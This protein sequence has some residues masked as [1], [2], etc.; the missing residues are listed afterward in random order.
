MNVAELSKSR[1]FNVKISEK[2]FLLLIVSLN[3]LIK[4]IPAAMVELG[5]DEVYYWTYALFP[6][7]S[8]FDHPPMVGFTIQLFTLN[9]SLNSEFFIR[10]GSLVLS[11]ASIIFLF[12]LVKRIY[13]TQAAYISAFLFTAS[14]YFNVISGL[15]ILPDTPQVFFVVVALFFGLPAVLS[16]NP[17]KKDSLDFILFGLFSGLAFL[18]KYHSLFLWAGVGLYILFCNRIWLKKI[19]FYL[20]ILLTV[21]AIIPVIY[22]NSINEFVSFTFHESRVSLFSKPLNLSSFLQFNAGQFFYQNPFLFIL[23]ILTLY[24][25]FRNRRKLDHK[26]ILLLLLSLPLIILFILFSLFQKTLP[27]WSG[28]A[29]IG[30][31]ILSCGWLTERLLIRLRRIIVFIASSV[32]FIFIML[33]FSILQI[34]YGLLWHAQNLADP[35]KTGSNDLTLEMYGWKQARLK[36]HELLKRKGI[37]EKD[38]NKVK[39]ISNK[40]FPAAHIDYY[41]AHPMNIDLL[42]P[43]QLEQSHKYFWINKRRNIDSTDSVF[44][45]TTS[46]QYYDPINLIDDPARIISRDTIRIQRNGR[47]AKNVF[48]FGIKGPLKNK[49]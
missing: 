29:F 33:F 8:H 26:E 34:N 11:S 30:L 47:I 15:F 41:I 13:S 49:P 20:S 18:S 31:I 22:W 23:F 14:V 37:E 32:L 28:P 21:M 45:L 46:L 6:D 3:F 38:Y 48:V 1:I 5:N 27:H 4:S 10:L 35:K 43:G 36:F 44:F 7:W 25:L 19:S 42:V 2:L 17:S 9:L 16:R 39:I 12:Y 24:S 40:W